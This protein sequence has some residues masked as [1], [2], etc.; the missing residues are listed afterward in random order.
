[1]LR[2]RKPE[3]KRPDR[4]LC[5]LTDYRMENWRASRWS[6]RTRSRPSRT[7]TTRGTSCRFSR[8]AHHLTQLLICLL[9]PSISCYR[10]LES[11][12]CEALMTLQPLGLLYISVCIVILLLW[13]CNEFEFVALVF[14][15][16]LSAFTDFR[17]G[18]CC[19]PSVPR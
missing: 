9:G 18:I 3:R 13:L 14:C 15:I 8:A 5:R 11:F 6:A 4:F 19:T 12:L 7:A 16:F 17:G 1:M 2:G 10:E